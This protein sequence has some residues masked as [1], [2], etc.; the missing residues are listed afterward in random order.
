MRRKKGK[1]G[2]Q[3]FPV[4]YVEISNQTNSLQLPSHHKPKTIQFN[5]MVCGTALGDLVT[6]KLVSLAIHSLN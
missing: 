2:P 6:A 3:N 1:H 5:V 4:D